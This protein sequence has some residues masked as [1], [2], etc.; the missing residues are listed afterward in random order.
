MEHRHA[1][2][3]DLREAQLEDRTLLAGPA[4]I[5]PSLVNPNGFNTYFTVWGFQSPLG[6]SIGA[7]GPQSLRSS[8]T[9]GVPVISGST[10]GFTLI[11]GNYPGYIAGL[12]TP[13]TGGVGPASGGQGSTG[14][15]SGGG[16]LLALASSVSGGSSSEHNTGPVSSSSNMFGG[17]GTSFSTGGNF[18]SSYSGTYNGFSTALQFSS[19]GGTRTPTGT[20][21]ATGEE[22]RDPNLDAS[23]SPSY[24]SSTTGLPPG[25]PDGL[26]Y[27][28]TI[29]RLG[30][31]GIQLYTRD[32]VPGSM[33]NTGTSSQSR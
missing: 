10:L 1:F 33:G 31:G 24:N 17:Y 15:F 20:N 6:G 26:N 30:A 2:R 9:S 8:F 3:P 16:P 27:Y 19:S 13:T 23:P 12:G 32:Q 7:T 29:R 21:S 11:S 5:Y 18:A 22:V 25:M 28:D 4:G 14:G